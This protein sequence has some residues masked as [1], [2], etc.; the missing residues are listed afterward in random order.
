MR[1]ILSGLQVNSE[2]MRKNAGLTGDLAL[3]EAAYSLLASQGV[4]DAHERIRVATLGAERDGESL[5][6]MLR[7][8]SDTW[9]TLQTAL[10]AVSVQSPDEFF[11]D[12]GNYTGRAREIA[13]QLAD[14]YEVRMNRL[15]EESF[16]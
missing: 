8:E 9:E 3:A 11:S 1:K 2:R 14:T 13:L 10:K 5:L 6:T 15:G 16:T 12:P 4:S 7:A